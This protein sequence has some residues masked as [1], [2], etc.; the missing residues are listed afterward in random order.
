MCDYRRE[1][2]EK[3]EQKTSKH[4]NE[5]PNSIIWEAYSKKLPGS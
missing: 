5:I 4:G 1:N 2:K 3:R